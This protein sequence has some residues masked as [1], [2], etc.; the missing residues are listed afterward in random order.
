MMDRARK[1]PAFSTSK[2]LKIPIW[3]QAVIAAGNGVQQG[4]G[5]V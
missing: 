1:K 2:V 3:L 4:L 5:H